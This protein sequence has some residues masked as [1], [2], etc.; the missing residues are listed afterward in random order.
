VTLRNT[1]LSNAPSANCFQGLGTL[2]SSGNNLSSDATCAASLTGPGDLNNTNPLLGPLANNGGPTQTHALLA[3]SPA[4][5]AAGGCPPPATDQRGVVRPQ[6]SACD[7][8]S[9]EFQGVGPTATPTA[10]GPVPTSTPTPTIILTQT[11]TVTFGPG[12]PAVN[13][14]TLSGPLLALLGL[15]LAVAGYLLLRRA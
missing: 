12:G 14:P 9:F 3:G 10:T 7:I 8:G 5:D 11:P 15:V 2:V 13:V 4:I 6:G 1:I